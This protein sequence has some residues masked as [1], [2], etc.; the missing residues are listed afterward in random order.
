MKS[1]RGKKMTKNKR[2]CELLLLDF[3]FREVHASKRTACRREGTFTGAA[4]HLGFP[5][6]RP[7]GGDNS[8]FLFKLD[9]NFFKCNNSLIF[10]AAPIPSS[11]CTSRWTS[12]C[13]SGR[14]ECLQWEFVNSLWTNEWRADTLLLS[15]KSNTWSLPREWSQ[16]VNGW[17]GAYQGG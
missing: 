16:N 3:F 10:A 17:M 13:V 1:G 15:I 12:V 9:T 6:G 11:G 8:G 4:A 14:K 5:S 7:H 2:H